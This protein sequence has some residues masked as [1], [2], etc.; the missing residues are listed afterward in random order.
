MNVAR[1][2]AEAGIENAKAQM[3]VET[4]RHDKRMAEIDIE[5]AKAVEAG[6][7]QADAIWAQIEETKK[8]DAAMLGL[9]E[10]TAKYQGII[11]GTNLADFTRQFNDATVNIQAMKVTMGEVEAASPA[12]LAALNEAATGMV[13][14]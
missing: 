13:T 2:E 9:N 10:Q 1:V 4:M 11:A 3:E 12:L 8:Y 5:L 14:G 6:K 7:S